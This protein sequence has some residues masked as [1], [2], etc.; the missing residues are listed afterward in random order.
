MSGIGYGVRVG[1][2]TDAPLRG[3]LAAN[4]EARRQGL[5]WDSPQRSLRD[6]VLKT[7]AGEQS[8]ATGRH[9][10]GSLSV[11]RVDHSSAY[12]QGTV[13]AGSYRHKGAVFIDR[14][15]AGGQESA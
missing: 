2:A 8:V 12:S 5:P 7:A 14:R 10:E 6:A 13:A 9:A 11:A 1:I 3:N 15:Q 4:F